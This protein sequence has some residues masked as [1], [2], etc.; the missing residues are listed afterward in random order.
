MTKSCRKHRPNGPSPAAGPV[1]PRREPVM[2]R[3]PH[4]VEPPLPAEDI[5]RALRRQTELLLEI[6]TLLGS[7]TGEQN[8]RE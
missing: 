6:R 8:R 5:T 7:L 4:P 2:Q 1:P 3:W